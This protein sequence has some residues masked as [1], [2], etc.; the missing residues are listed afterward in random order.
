MSDKIT[1]LKANWLDCLLQ[2]ENLQKQI[3]AIQQ[4]IVRLQ[5][6]PVAQKVK[7]VET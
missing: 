6:E 4:E 1:E 2:M 3:Q 7:S 5:T